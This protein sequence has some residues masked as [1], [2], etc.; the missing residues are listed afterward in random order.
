M[1]K[2]EKLP[3]TVYVTWSGDGKDRYLSASESLDRTVDNPGDKNR[4]G[5]YE[6]K[7]Q[8]DVEATVVAKAVSRRAARG[9]TST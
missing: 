1:A 2:S 3:Q 5:V 9:G 4:V 6:L 8:L 7:E